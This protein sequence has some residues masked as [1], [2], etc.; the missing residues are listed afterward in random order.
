MDNDLRAPF[1]P[2]HGPDGAR[3]SPS[4]FVTP[5]I[6]ERVSS[7][8]ELRVTRARILFL[9][10]AILAL[11][12]GCGGGKKKEITTLQRKEA[13]ALDS[14]AQFAFTVKDFAR[15]EG[16]LARATELAPDT[17]ALWLRLGMM[18]MRLGQRDGAK[19]AYKSALAAFQDAAE[20]VE[21]D[22][23][24]AKRNDPEPMLQQVTALALLGRVDDARKVITQITKR[25]PEHRAVRTFVEQ[26]NLD[27]MLADPQFK[28]LAL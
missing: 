23:D 26:K 1:L 9:L 19:A 20:A 5:V 24:P 22:P 25:F 28:E 6:D 10:A 15:A 16:L 27:R 8:S 21:D 13:A 12:A 2:R 17:G 7:V 11:G 18:R 4:T 3:K 14:E